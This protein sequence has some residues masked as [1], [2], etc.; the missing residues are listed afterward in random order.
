M[1]DD[2]IEFILNEM[3]SMFDC[4]PN[5]MTQPRAFRY[6]IKLYKHIKT[7]R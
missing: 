7:L 1:T 4:L 6:Y 5:P 3:E 2:E